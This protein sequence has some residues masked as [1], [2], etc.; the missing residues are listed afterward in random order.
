MTARDLPTIGLP[1]VTQMLDGAL[2][3]ALAEHQASRAPSV[4]AV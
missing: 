2:M 1:A 3:P 4:A